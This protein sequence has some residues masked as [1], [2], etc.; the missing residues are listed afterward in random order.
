MLAAV[1]AAALALAPAIPPEPTEPPPETWILSGPTGTVYGTTGTFE[2]TSSDEMTYR[3]SLDGSATFACASPYTTPVLALGSHRFTVAGRGVGGWDISPDVSTWTIA[4]APAP[5]PVPT[6]TPAPTTTPPDPAPVAT[7]TPTPD[8]V[9]QIAD[10]KGATVLAATAPLAPIDVSLL[11]F[12]NAKKRFTRFATLSVKGV[13]AGATITVTCMGGGCPRKTQTL[14]SAKGGTVKLSTWLRK[15]LKTGA[16]LNITVT[17]PG[18]QGM[19]KTLTMR[20]ERRPRI[21]TNSGS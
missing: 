15:R 17:R 8:P 14:T 2:F 19:T 16:T 18:M 3:C 21:V 9:A 4:T 20:P 12:M 5:T 10:T 13:P 7:A 1:A 6:A 11:Y